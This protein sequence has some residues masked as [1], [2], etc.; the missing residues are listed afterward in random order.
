LEPDSPI[1]GVITPELLQPGWLLYRGHFIRFGGTWGGNLAQAIDVMLGIDT[2]FRLL[3]FF[4]FSATDGVRA[5]E[6]GAAARAV[7]ED[8]GLVFYF[9]DDTAPPFAEVEGAEGGWAQHAAH[10]A[11]RWSSFVQTLAPPAGATGIVLL[12][13]ENLWSGRAAW[14]YLGDSPSRLLSLTDRFL[15]PRSESCRFARQI[16]TAPTLAAVDAAIE[17]MVQWWA[18]SHGTAPP[19]EVQLFVETQQTPEGVN[20]RPSAIGWQLLVE[21]LIHEVFHIAWR[22]VTLNHGGD[23]PCEGPDFTD[24][25]ETL[26]A[27]GTSAHYVITAAGAFLGEAAVFGVA[28]GEDAHSRCCVADDGGRAPDYASEGSCP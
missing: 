10:I 8:G 12:S 5:M 6:V 26:V 13:T 21:V 17:D 16:R 3:P 9:G 15:A 4:G 19:G 27:S 7:V 1:D 25:A 28:L 18:A 2:M 23:D 24:F 14:G 11:P 20:H 22:M